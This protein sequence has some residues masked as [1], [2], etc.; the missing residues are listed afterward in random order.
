MD[1]NSAKTAP[2]NSFHPSDQP[3]TSEKEKTPTEIESSLF[4]LEVLQS[5]LSHL[6][7]ELL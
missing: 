4:E 3:S 7:A 6:N 2:I 1:K 5:L